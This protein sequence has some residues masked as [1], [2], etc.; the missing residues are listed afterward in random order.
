VEII[1]GCDVYYPLAPEEE[2]RILVNLPEKI[3]APIEKGSAAGSVSFWLGE[4]E[5]GR[6]DLLFDASVRDDCSKSGSALTRLL[7]MIREKDTA[8]A[9]PRT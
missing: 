2:V 8:A 7:N 3:K 9:L 6:A 4:E 5:I 1:A